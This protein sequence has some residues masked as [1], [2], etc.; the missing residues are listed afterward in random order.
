MPTTVIIPAGSTSTLVGLAPVDDAVLEVTETVTAT[1]SGSGGG[2]SV[3]S[4]SVADM[5]IAD[6]DAS[7]LPEV[8]LSVPDAEATEGGD[9]ASFTIALAAPAA[10]PIT[11]H[12]S[13]SGTAVNGTDYATLSGVANIPGG[14]SSATIQVSPINDAALEGAET[15]YI[16]LD[17]DSAYVLGGVSVC[18]ATIADD[19]A[20][21]VVPKVSIVAVSADIFEGTTSN[22]AFTV[23]IDVPQTQNLTVNIRCSGGVSYPQDYR[24]V[25]QFVIIAAGDTSTNINLDAVDDGLAEGR[26]RLDVTILSGSGYAVQSPAEATVWISDPIP[27]PTLAMTQTTSYLEEGQTINFT[28]TLSRPTT[29]P[30]VVSLDQWTDTAADC[31]FENPVTIPV[32][33][34]QKVV[35]FRAVVDGAAEGSEGVGISI[36]PSADFTTNGYTTVNFFISDPSPPAP[37]TPPASSDA[38]GGGGGGC[39]SGGL[40]AFVLGTLALGLRGKRRS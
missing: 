39:G 28:L 38:G 7:G 3:G 6:N 29:I 1:I 19:E 14:S 37:V 2:Y 18:R 10:A 24:G 15:V 27:K 23:S 11:V 13:V 26:E 31:E 40:A 5:S 36:L 25:G 16:S 30:I 33:D 34:T 32:G 21:G 9:G 4:P 35:V 8:S 20:V 17:A 12:Y 22:L